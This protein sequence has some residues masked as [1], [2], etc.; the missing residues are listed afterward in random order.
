MFRRVTS[1]RVSASS[2]PLKPITYVRMWNAS[3]EML[4]IHVLYNEIPNHVSAFGC[5]MDGA[6]GSL[7]KSVYSVGESHVCWSAEKQLEPSF[8]A[9][10]VVA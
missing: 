2:H 9:D 10:I 7:P 8:R 6:A 1:F 4:E 5:V 3:R